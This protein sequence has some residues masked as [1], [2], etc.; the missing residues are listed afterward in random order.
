MVVY[1]A[2]YTVAALSLAVRRFSRR[3]I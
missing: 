1:G 3:D 2:V